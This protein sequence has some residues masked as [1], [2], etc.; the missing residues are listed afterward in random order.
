MSDTKPDIVIPG[1]SAELLGQIFAANAS[2]SEQISNRVEENYRREASDWK[3]AFLALYDAVD[4]VNEVV[5]S[6]RIDNVLFHF[7]Q[8]A[9]HA[10]RPGWWEQELS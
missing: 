7:G 10:D 6:K 8:K 1:E 3:R 5:D 9:A 2:W 4:R